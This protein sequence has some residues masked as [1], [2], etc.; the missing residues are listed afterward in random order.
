MLLCA[1]GFLRTG[2]ANERRGTQQRARNNT[3]QRHAGRRVQDGSGICVDWSRCSKQASER[4]MRVVASGM[5]E[6]RLDIC[7]VPSRE[8]NPSFVDLAF[9]E[10]K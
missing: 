8:R 5:H 3:Q 2:L 6:G 7:D 1:S 10:L 4:A 9:G